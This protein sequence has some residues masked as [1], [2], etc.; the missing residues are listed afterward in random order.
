[1]EVVQLILK[2]EPGLTLA[3]L[4]ARHPDNVDLQYVNVIGM[5]SAPREFRNKIAPRTLLAHADEVVE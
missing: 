2:V 4:R 3:Q 1:M 5:R